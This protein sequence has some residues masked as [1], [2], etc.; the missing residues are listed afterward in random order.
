MGILKKIYEV[1]KRFLISIFLLYSFNLVMS[2]LE[3]II[4]INIITVT[5]ITVLG[6]PALFSLLVIL[7]FIY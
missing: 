5:F 4:P 2:P 3:I 1:I 6:I 7:L